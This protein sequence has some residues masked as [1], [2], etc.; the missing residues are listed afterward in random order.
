M[1]KC[2][3]PKKTY[4]SV[5]MS[6][7]HAGADVVFEDLDWEGVY[8]LKPYPIYDSAKRLTSNMY[9]PESFMCLSF[10][11]KKQ[12]AIGKGGMILTDDYKAVEW[13]Y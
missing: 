2:I 12:L 6:I 1:Y 3:I 10:H 7:I 11:V 8:Q 5:P 4:L 9:V 13:F